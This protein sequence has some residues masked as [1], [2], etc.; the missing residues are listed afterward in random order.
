MHQIYNNGLLKL[1]TLDWFSSCDFLYMHFCV[2]FL[3]GVSKDLIYDFFK[4]KKDAIFF[5]KTVIKK[6]LWTFEWPKMSHIFRNT[7]HNYS[8][9]DLNFFF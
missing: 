7:Y 2:W 1:K 3:F 4:R 6:T 8:W 9:V 5:I